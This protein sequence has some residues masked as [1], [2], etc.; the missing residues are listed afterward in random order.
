MATVR[1]PAGARIYMADAAIGTAQSISGITKASPGVL[2]YSGADSFTNGSYA[3]MTSMFGM[4][5]LEDALVRVANANTT[6]N[7]FDL[8]DQDTSGYGTFVS[9]NVSPVTIAT[10]INTAT[11][12]TISG[13]DQK[14]AEYTFLWDKITRKY[15]TTKDGMVI[16]IPSIWDPQD[17][18]SLAIQAASDASAKRAFKIVMPDGLEILFFGYIGS[19]GLPNVQNIN[20]VMQ[21][22]FTIVASSRVRYAF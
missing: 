4:T 16:K 2:T 3:A 5:E 15:P 14:F 12:F 10:E 9:G 6:S 13:G 18:G 22:E 21:T 19:S 20:D 8:E 1:S 11:G 17:A 7:T